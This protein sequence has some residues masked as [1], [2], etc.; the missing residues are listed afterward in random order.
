MLTSHGYAIKYVDGFKIRN[1]LDDDFGIIARQSTSIAHFSPKYYIP[2][3]EL[4]V[5]APFHAEL[6]FLLHVEF[7]TD[8]H[9]E[10]ARLPYYKLR[11]HFQKELCLPGPI[12]AFKYSSSGSDPAI[13]LVDGSLV[14]RYLDPDFIFGGHG[15]VY[16]YIPKD[17]IWLDK[18][19]ERAE[20]PYIE[21]HERV[22][23]DLMEQGATY[24][25]AHDVATASDKRLRR[26]AGNSYPGD[27]HYPW[28]GQTNAD[29]I[30]HYYIN[31]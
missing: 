25:E 2:S 17:E 1:T 12:P 14:R 6:E 23:R 9:P 27:K 19:M 26:H 8:D 10:F 7:Y 13:V 4:W 5:E 11:E 31:Q 30:H 21:H 22:E 28:H 24:D 18:R 15:Y 29:L 16:S 20:I 3:G